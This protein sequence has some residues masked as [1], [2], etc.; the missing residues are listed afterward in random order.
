MLLTLS[1]LHFY[2]SKQFILSPISMSSIMKTAAALL[3]PLVYAAPAF[4]PP[5]ELIQGVI[6]SNISFIAG[7]ALPNS[8]ASVELLDVVVSGLQLLASLENSEA[9]FYS[10]AILTLPAGFTTLGICF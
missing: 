4:P 2:L 9:Y 6:N 1:N 3:L 8:S 5:A 10:E 7:G